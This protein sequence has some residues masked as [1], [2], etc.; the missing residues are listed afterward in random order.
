MHLR[1]T[2]NL[3]WVD[4]DGRCRAAP[5]L[6]VRLVLD[7]GHRLLFAD[8]RRFGTGVVI[9]G[10]EALDDYLA[11]R[12]GPEPLDPAF[13]PDVLRAAARGRR[14]PVKAFL[15]DQRRV[16]GVGNIYA[17]E[18]L[19]RA[20]H[21]S[22]EAG[23]PAAARRDRA[24]ARGDRRRRSR[25]ASRARARRSTTTATSNGERGSMQDEFLIHLRE[26]AAV[27]ALRPP[28]REAASRPGRGTY[29]CRRCQPAP[30]P[31]ARAGAMS[32]PP[33]ARRLRRPATGPTPE[34]ATGCTVVLAAAGGRG[35]VGRRA[36]RRPG[37][38]R[39]RPAAPA[40]QRGR[41]CTRSC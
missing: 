12:L 40:R 38:A 26:G 4:A 13:T 39:D 9:D 2:G 34:A 10:R 8:Q 41:A 19:F 5:H 35:R 11:E 21:P 22:A 18:A 36:R 37:H 24:A 27:P 16:A 23:R 20:R 1:M 3:L 32:E 6:R 29:V 15:L 33:A 31:P 25:R 28:G 7:D 30:R 17:D 14:A